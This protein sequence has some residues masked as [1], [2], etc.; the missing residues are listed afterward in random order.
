L[1][2]NLNEGKWSTRKEGTGMGGTSILLKA[3][4]EVSGKAIDKIKAWLKTK[5]PAEKNALR[6]SA[7]YREVVKRLEAERDAKKQKVDATPLVDEVDAL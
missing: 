5:S 6:E 3:I 7:T 1:I 2:D 4:V